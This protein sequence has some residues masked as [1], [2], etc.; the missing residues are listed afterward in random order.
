MLQQLCEEHT[1]L[2]CGDIAEIIATAQKSKDNQKYANFD[3]FIDVYD[4]RTHEALVVWHLRP[5]KKQSLYEK[6]VVGKLA[7]LK[8]EP[9][10][11][12]TLQTGSDSRRLLAMTQEGKKVF[13]TI[14]PIR[15]NKKTIGVLIL[16]SDNEEE[17]LNE[18]QDIS[19][20][21]VFIDGELH[22][23]DQF[24]ES[25]LIYDENGQC[26]Y[27]NHPAEKL[28]RKLGYKGNLNT[29][30]YDNMSLDYTTFEYLQY[31]FTVKNETSEV[32]E[33]PYQDFT[34]LTKK[35]WFPKSNHILVLIED[36]TEE[37]RKELE[38]RTKEVMIQEIHHRIKNNLQSIVSLLR[39]QE[40][41][42]NS[43]EAKKV[44]QDSSSRILAIAQTHQLLSQHIDGIVSLKEMVENLT[45]NL[46]YSLAREG[47]KI[48]LDIDEEIVLNTE[49]M[50]TLS[51]ILN[52]IIANAYE[53]AFD[54]K[55]EGFIK[56]TAKKKRNKI[57]LLVKDNG[58]GFDTKTAKR[59][60][61][62]NIIEMYV[63]EKLSGKL[64]VTS[65]ANGTHNRIQF[66]ME[67]KETS[68][69]A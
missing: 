17:I 55:Q 37:K 35:I 51:L 53:H 57:D 40:R 54:E 43:V 25:I 4:E 10:V 67:D 30:H 42:T 66:I 34:F 22:Y 49:Q 6:E 16:E 8:D 24:V 2:E 36:K 7:K 32:S 56:I 39:L 41:R 48:V 47:I 64:E 15:N 13:Q 27:H 21:D 65:S 69:D 33:N 46:L 12:R 38:L 5:K 28:Y 26:F 23:Y 31:L 63:T 1:K 11:H 19:A 3:V 52:E 18:V 58:K 45:R 61:G 29:Y 44:L 68:K 59:N 20:F 62:M 14:Y 9:G 60:L 50:I